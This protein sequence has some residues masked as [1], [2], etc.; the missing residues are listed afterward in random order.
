MAETKS[1]SNVVEEATEILDRRGHC[2]DRLE[3]EHG[4]VCAVQA[5]LLATFPTGWGTLG[6]DLHGVGVSLSELVGFNNHPDTTPEMVTDRLME[7]AKRLRN[8]GK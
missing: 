2:K 3:D 8:E 4:R 1:A 7:I 6:E 5:L